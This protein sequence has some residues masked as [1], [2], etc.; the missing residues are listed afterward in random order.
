MTMRLALARWL[1]HEPEPLPVPSDAARLKWSAWK[2][3]RLGVHEARTSAELCSAVVRHAA[4]RT[5]TDA[6]AAPRC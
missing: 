1:W 2:A 4:P 6:L 5:R 3:T